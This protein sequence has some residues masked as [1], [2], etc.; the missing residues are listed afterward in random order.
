MDLIIIG[1]V[2]CDVVAVNI[3]NLPHWNTDTLAS[4]SLLAG[5]TG[6]NNAV[7]ASNYI[8]WLQKVNNLDADIKV[9]IF[10]SICDD[11]NGRICQSKLQELEP[12][13]INHS[14]IP[15]TEPSSANKE[16]NIPMLHRTSTCIVISGS[17]DRCFIT[18]RGCISNLA[19][20]WFC[21]RDILGFDHQ[22]ILSSSSPSSSSTNESYSKRH[23]HIAGYYNCNTL[24]IGLPEFLKKVSI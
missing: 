21:P 13:L 2:I 19:I 22:P 4:I 23:I 14:I 20:D 5:G 8:K 18:D 9:H 7:H 11:S 15:P 24:P 16:I 12:V 17:N 3:A 10:S 1:D 6:L